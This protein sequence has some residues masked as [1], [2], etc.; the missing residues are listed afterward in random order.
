M[1]SFVGP[2]KRI[3][4][5]SFQLLWP[6]NQWKK[7]NIPHHHPYF[8]SIFSIHKNKSNQTFNWHHQKYPFNWNELRAHFHF[9]RATDFHQ[10]NSAITEDEIWIW[11]LIGNDFSLT[12]AAQNSNGYATKSILLPSFTALY[13]L[14]ILCLISIIWAISQTN[15]WRYT[16]TS[17]LTAV[18]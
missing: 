15:D 5:F 2:W 12:M 13:V 16:I 11:M 10:P 3:F 7:S 9:I 17:N 8:S 14:W 1:H 4:L 6:L 18:W